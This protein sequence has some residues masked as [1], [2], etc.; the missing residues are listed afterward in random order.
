MPTIRIPSALRAYVQGQGEVS[1]HGGTVREV[2]DDLVTQFPSFR[3]HLFS[4][5][6][7]LRNYVHLFLSN[8]DIK[9]LNGMDTN[10]SANDIINLVPSIAGG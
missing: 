6:G 2:M 3:E 10:L 4:Q 5:D 9:Y 1:V 7:A 8:R